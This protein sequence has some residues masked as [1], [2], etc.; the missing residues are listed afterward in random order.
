MVRTQPL[1]A[2]VDDEEA[3]C[4][5]LKRLLNA[6][7]LEV[8]TFSSGKAFLEALASTRPDCAVLDLHMPGLS[9]LDLLKC[10]ANAGESV[11]VIIITGR[12]EHGAYGACLAAGALAYLPKPLD[13]AKL[14]QAIEKALLRGH[15]EA[16]PRRPRNGG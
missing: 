16:G 12:D 7:R 5:A 4:R 11:P 13:H 10:L 3:V 14:L 8:V 15:S 6:S 1:I 2:V 9:G